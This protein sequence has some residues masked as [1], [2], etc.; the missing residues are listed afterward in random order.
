VK[1]EVVIDA[2]QKDYDC[3]YDAAGEYTV[4]VTV[5]RGGE[6]V[7]DTVNVNVFDQTAV[8]DLG[9]SVPTRVNYSDPDGSEGTW[10]SVIIGLRALNLGTIDLPEFSRIP[11]KVTLDSDPNLSGT[12]LE[13]NR[14]SDI[15]EF[16]D[17]LGSTESSRSLT[18]LLNDV[19]FGTS[20]VQA[21][22]NLDP[23][24]SV[25]VSDSIYTESGAVL[26]NNQRENEIFFPV[27][28]PDMQIDVGNG[29]VRRGESAEIEYS[30]DVTYNSLE[31]QFY[32]PGVSIVTYRPAT[33]GPGDVVTTGPLT[34]KTIYTLTCTEEYTQTT[35]TEEATIEVVGTLEET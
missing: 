33:D 3:T 7:S 28:R 16:N 14:T 27:P 18:R 22:V 13:A 9:A 26:D 10:G 23:T 34:A 29:F 5:T 12:L 32:G 2:D 4:E 1:H 21:R 8:F 11:Y 19:P 24:T 20:T 17:D 35:F 31:C 25:T 30:V 6:T 15:G